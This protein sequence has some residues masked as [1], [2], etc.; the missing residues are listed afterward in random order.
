MNKFCTN[1]LLISLLS[2]PTISNADKLLITGVDTTSSSS[3]YLFVGALIP[4]PDNSLAH[5][6]V[7]HLWT[8]YLEYSYDSG[9]TKIKAK[10]NS[11]SVAV[12]Y[13]DSGSKYWWNAKIGASRGKTRLTPDDLGNKSR[14]NVTDIKLGLSGERRL[15]SSLKINGIA[16]YG[17]DRESYWTRVRLLGKINDQMYHG[18]EVIYQGDPSYDIQQFGWA[19]EGIAVQEHTSLGIKAGVRKDGNDSSSY[20]GVDMVVFY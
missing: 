16:D 13:H 6:L 5:G 19:V 20:A 9:A 12:A 15:S 11:V 18:P 17:I 4:L 14:G 1:I 8:D 2:M 7:M 10:A 3:S